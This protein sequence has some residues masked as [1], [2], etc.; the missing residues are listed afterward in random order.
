MG[1]ALMEIRVALEELLNRTSWIE[2]DGDVVRTN[3]ERFGVSSLPLRLS[4]IGE[5]HD[6]A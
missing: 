5:R 1:L 3:W 6:D 4:P 2:L